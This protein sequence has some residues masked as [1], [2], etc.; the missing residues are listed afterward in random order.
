MC[1]EV[2]SRIVHPEGPAQP[3]LWGV[4]QLT[5]SGDEMQASL[6]RLPDH[7]DP[8]AAGG[9]E[10]GGAVEDGKGTDVLGP[11]SARSQH[12]PVQWGQPVNGHFG[13]PPAGWDRLE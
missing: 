4:D 8:E 11:P 6:D 12:H 1:A 3:P 2:E 9:I 7:L 5:E 10:P 13:P